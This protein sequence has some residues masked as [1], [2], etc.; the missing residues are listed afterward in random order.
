MLYCLLKLWLYCDRHFAVNNLKKLKQQYFIKMFPEIILFLKTVQIVHWQEVIVKED[1][2]QTEWYI[3]SY[4]KIL[5]ISFWGLLKYLLKLSLKKL[6]T[7][8]RVVTVIIDNS[9][10]KLKFSIQYLLSLLSRRW[11]NSDTKVVQ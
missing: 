11:S 1:L 6:L 4:S 10:K 5:I 7:S 8:T 9:N 3:F 2:Y